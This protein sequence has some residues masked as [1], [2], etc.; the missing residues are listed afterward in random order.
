MMKIDRPGGIPSLQPIDVRKL[1]IR[2]FSTR[3]DM[4]EAAAE[5]AASILERLLERYEYVN[6]VF[7]AAPSQNEFLQALSKLEFL[8]WG[9]VNAFHLDEYIGLPPKH[10]QRFSSFLDERIFKVLPFHKVHYI[11]PAGCEQTDPE[12]LAE[13]YE[14]LLKKNTLHLAC[15]GVGENGHIAF[16]EPYQARFD[17]DKLVRV[18]RLDER[19][20]QQQLND[21]CF[22]RIEDV[23]THAITLTVPAIMGAEYIICVVPGKSKAEAVFKS[24]EGPIDVSCPASVLRRHKSAYVFLDELS[25][26]LLRRC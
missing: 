10:P 16:N 18:V 8:D 3:K 9:R 14:Q 6:V 17:D 5:Q 13:R 22:E 1:E 20:R 25:A 11:I 15:I 12:I 19:S 4:G 26:S 23:P 24:L 2:I 7:A 21:A